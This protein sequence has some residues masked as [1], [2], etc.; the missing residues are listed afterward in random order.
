MVEPPQDSKAPAESPPPP[1]TQFSQNRQQPGPATSGQ[2]YWKDKR[3]QTIKFIYCADPSRDW[4]TQAWAAYLLV[5]C[6]DVPRLMREGFYW[7]SGNSVHEDGYIGSKIPSNIPLF[8]RQGE[9][10][11]F[12]RHYFLRDL[13]HPERWIATIEVYA[14]HLETLSHFD[15]SQL[16]PGTVRLGTAYSELGKD[17][18]QYYYGRPQLCFNAIYD[19]MPMEGQWPWPRGHAEG[20][21]G[22]PPMGRRWQ[23]RRRN[24]NN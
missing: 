4:N 13:K 14:V 9:P 20:K 7:D 18:Y 12:T 1:Y 11:A 24:P 23:W 22:N 15:L 6:S 17:I 19:D 8:R 21:E 10:W 5:K 2:W 16:S 3:R